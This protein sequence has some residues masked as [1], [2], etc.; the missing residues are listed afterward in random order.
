MDRALAASGVLVAAIDMTR[1]PRRD[2]AQSRGA[3]TPRR[4]VENPSSQPILAHT[5]GRVPDR[6]RGHSVTSSANRTERRA[7]ETRVTPEHAPASGYPQGS[8]VVNGRTRRG[9]VARVAALMEF[10]AGTLLDSA[11]FFVPS[12][13][14][15]CRPFQG[16]TW[17]VELSG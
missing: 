11:L 2:H 14:S 13:G 7:F 4:S 5:R 6:R 1:S 15:E 12:S 16:G 8:V 9:Y 17:C 10:R 3:C